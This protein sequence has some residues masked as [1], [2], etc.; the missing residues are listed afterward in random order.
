MISYYL[1]FAMY[2]SQK[3]DVDCYKMLRLFFRNL[4]KMQNALTEERDS[5]LACIYLLFAVRDVADTTP[6]KGLVRIEFAVGAVDV[7]TLSIHSK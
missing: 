4:I 7:Q 2:P 1:S 5:P 3:M 6:R